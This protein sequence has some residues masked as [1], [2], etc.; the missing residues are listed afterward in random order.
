MSLADD[1]SDVHGL[2]NTAKPSG[3]RQSPPATCVGTARMV[4]RPHGLLPLV[5]SPLRPVSI[6]HGLH[7]LLN[8]RDNTTGSPTAFSSCLAYERPPLLQRR[9][10][11]TKATLQA[12]CDSRAR[13]LSI[14][15][16]QEIKRV[17]LTVPEQNQGV[18]PLTQ[19]TRPESAQSSSQS[20]P[21]TL[22][23]CRQNRQPMRR[24]KLVAARRVMC[25]GERIFAPT[26]GGRCWHVKVNQNQCRFSVA[27]VFA[28]SGLPGLVLAQGHC[29]ERL[30][31]SR[32][33]AAAWWGRM[34][35]RASGG[36][37]LAAEARAL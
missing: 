21:A 26:K 8:L 4:P 13:R 29:A 14:A 17:K 1:N 24:W 12:A 34:N 9:V 15:S 3:P 36:G 32:V 2:N 11:G 6:S 33:V 22:R 28:A 25:R 23:I 30:K 20:R 19:T 18:A 37:S 27:P 10:L 5:P 35:L 31:R 16:V 7:A